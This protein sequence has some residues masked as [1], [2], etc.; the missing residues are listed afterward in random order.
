MG[1]LQDYLQH[2]T[3]NE[4]PELFHVWAAYA[5]LSAAVSRR[6]W[7]VDGPKAIYPNLYIML[8]GDTGCGKST[9]MWYSKRM[10]SELGDIALSRSVETPEGLWRFMA[11]DPNTSPPTES[12]VKFLSKWP[13]NQIRECHPMTII[14]NEF[15]N[16]I[17]KDREGWCGALNDI[18]DEDKYEYR[19][20]NKGEDLLVGPYIVILGALPTDISHDLQKAKIIS[21]GFA[22]RCI[23]QYGERKFHEP[24]AFI[25]F[26]DAQ[27][28]A[29]QRCIEHLRLVQKL[30]GAFEIPPETR[31]W[32]KV[33]YDAHTMA[34][35][36]VATPQ[37]KGW[38]SS[39]PNQVQKLA[40]LTCMAESLD[41]I[42]TIR[43]Y[44][45]AIDFLAEM[46]RDLYQVFGGVGRNELAAVAVKIHEFLTGLGTVISMRKLKANFFSSCKPPND[47]D[48]CMRYLIDSGKVVTYLLTVQ[49]P[50]GAVSDNVVA[51]PDNLKKFQDS[52]AQKASPT[53]SA[54]V[55]PVL[56]TDLMRGE[57][58]STE[59]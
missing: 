48:E 7:V 3:G 42:V 40:M 57:S 49:A 59:L 35:P 24:H 5:T 4:A 2:A 27:A 41:K 50:S 31:A 17:S 51:T 38:F 19:T 30:H 44:E 22:R 33:W 1:F 14:A 15:V 46:E 47:F 26:T 56:R 11:G 43:H 20:K 53:P 12:P 25:E 18:Y 21:S 39:K 32:W 37:T 6:V 10:L 54:A 9:A 23:F 34:I 58:P 36:K 52:V 8:V 13:D 28:S 16:F 45:I 55:L 29:R